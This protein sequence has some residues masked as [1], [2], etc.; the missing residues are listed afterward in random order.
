[1]KHMLL[2]LSLTLT[3]VPVITLERTGCYGPCP[4]YKLKIYEDGAVKYEGYEYV[5][6]KGKAEAQITKEALDKL[7]GAFEEIDYF[8]LNESYD[9]EGK[10][11]PQIW[12]DHP[13]ATTSLNWKDKKKTVRHYHGCRGN[14]VLDQLTALEDKIDEIVNTQR[15]IK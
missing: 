15:W 4:V 14:P 2:A 5:K 7:I 6:Q 11:C 1:M 8:K 3:V 9:S 12:T 13:T 10:H